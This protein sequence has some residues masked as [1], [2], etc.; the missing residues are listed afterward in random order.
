MNIYDVHALSTHNSVQ[1]HKHL[2]LALAVSPG[3][4]S[5]SK[6]APEGEVAPLCFGV[7]SSAGGPS[8]MWNPTKARHRS[9][10]SGH[11]EAPSV[12]TPDFVLSL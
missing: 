7:K 10:D 12:G 1:S 11:Y 5:E 2:Y 6:P 4:K 8:T 9:M 3:E